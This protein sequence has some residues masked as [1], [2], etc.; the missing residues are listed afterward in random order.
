MKEVPGSSE[1][2]VVTR[3]TRRNN[4]EDTIPHSHRREKLKSFKVDIQVNKITECCSADFWPEEGSDTLL[5]NVGSDTNN[6]ALYL[7]RNQL[8]T[9]N[10]FTVS[11][12]LTAE[13][14]WC[15]IFESC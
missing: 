13:I 10:M 9:M 12:Q 7:R 4:P 11:F 5:R 14:M 15:I 6:T 2:S 1:T 3:A 8:H